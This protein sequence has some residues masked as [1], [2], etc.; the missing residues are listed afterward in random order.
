MVLTHVQM[1]ALLALP[2]VSARIYDF[3]RR[4]QSRG[5]PFLRGCDH[6]Y[7]RGRG[8]GPRRLL[9]DCEPGRFSPRVCASTSPGRD[10]LRSPNPTQSR[11][12]FLDPKI[13]LPVNA[14]KRTMSHHF[15][16]YSSAMVYR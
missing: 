10:P 14:L 8:R 12:S 2:P 16:F 11:S 7:G 9:R 3:R 13:A 4:R 15:V 6:G 5:A 1:G